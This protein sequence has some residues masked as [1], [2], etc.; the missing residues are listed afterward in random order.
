MSRYPY[1]KEQIKFMVEHGADMTTNELAYALNKTFHT[2]HTAQSIRTVL[3]RLG[4]FKS[5]ETRSR[6]CAMKGKPIGSAKIIGG[7][8]YI[9][10]RQSSGGFYQ[11]WKREAQIVYENTYGDIPPE[12]MVVTLDGNKLNVAPE[13]LVA[14]SKSIAARMINGHGKSMWSEFPELTKTS[15]ET[16]KLD[17]IIDKYQKNA[18]EV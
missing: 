13:N 5:K 9:K 3:K 18:K 14:I 10:V 12:Y 8:R 15:I 7:Y 2:N 4:I 6:L 16:C 17:E 11:D 1:T